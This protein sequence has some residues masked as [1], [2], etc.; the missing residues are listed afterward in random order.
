MKKYSQIFILC[1]FLIGCIFNP[2]DEISLSIDTLAP[3]NISTFSCHCGGNISASGGDPLLIKGVCWSTHSDP[4]TLDNIITTDDTSSTYICE[5]NNLCSLT[6]Y[7]IRAFATNKYGTSYGQEFSFTT[8]NNILLGTWKRSYG[9]NGDWCQFTF[10]DNL[11]YQYY[12]T[13]VMNEIPSGTYT[14]DNS[15]ILLSTY[16][17]D[18]GFIY[19]IRGDTLIISENFV[20]LKE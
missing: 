15:R 18:F 16:E 4:T 10:N 19:C 8:S 11:T 9:E 13:D 14:F 5:I 3:E 12:Y 17:G 7:Y 20:Y 1:T 2:I 6:T